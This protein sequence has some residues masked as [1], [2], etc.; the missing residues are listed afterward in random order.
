[1]IEVRNL[2]KKFG[3]KEILK[4]IDLTVKTGETVAILGPSGS[5]KTTLLR[6]LNFLEQADSGTLKI[7][8]DFVDFEKATKEDILRIRRKT[9]M[10]FQQY[11]LLANMT[12]LENIMEGLITPRNMDKDEARALATS[13][14]EDVGLKGFED[15]YPSQL[16]GGQQ[17][18]VGIARALAINPEV[19][20]F[21]EPTSAL[22]PELVGEI[23]E[24]IQKVAEQGVTMVIVTHEIA[25][26]YE[27]AD[28]VIFMEEG[29]IVEQGPPKEVIGNPKEART[30]EFL[31]KTVFSQQGELIN[32]L[33]QEIKKS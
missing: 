3:D 21:D 15:Y 11:N 14:M 9:S 23:L 26:A 30:K 25:F 22:D 29:Y 19:I 8:D 20:L 33:Q 4:G 13:L 5:G 31:E 6:C 2:K 24:L 10:V 32:E 18:R 27:V 12:A 7:D 17:Q 28:K 16:S 1:M